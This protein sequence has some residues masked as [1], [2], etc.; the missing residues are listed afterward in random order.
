MWWAT[1]VAALLVA[2]PCAPHAQAVAYH[3]GTL[4][5]VL[6][7]PH[8]GSV[9]LG[10]PARTG[11]HDL[12]A[13]G[14]ESNMYALALKTSEALRQRCGAAPAVVA[15]RLHRSHVDVNRAAA[16]CCVV[17][18]GVSPDAKAAYDAYHGN[19]TVA[20]AQ[21]KGSGKA[22]IL[23]MHG[24]ASGRR[25]PPRIDVGTGATATELR[26]YPS[27]PASTSLDVFGAPADL[28]WGDHSLG[29]LLEAEFNG[30]SRACPSKGAPAPEAANGGT[31]YFSGG[32]ISREHSDATAVGGMQL[33][34]PYE[35]HSSSA[36]DYV[37]PPLANAIAA[38][39]THYGVAS[40]TAQPSGDIVSGA[41]LI[42]DGQSGRLPGGKT[43][44]R[45][46]PV[47]GC[48]GGCE[49]VKLRIQVDVVS[50]SVQVRGALLDAAGALVARTSEAPAPGDVT[51]S[52]Q[53]GIWV[54]LPFTPGTTISDGDYWH[55]VQASPEPKIRW[56]DSP[57][58]PSTC[59]TDAWADGLAAPASPDSYSKR[60]WSGA[61][62]GQRT[63]LHVAPP[64]ARPAPLP[65]LPPH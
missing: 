1:T 10:W 21:A 4:P 25:S 34:M 9:D 62:K 65:L 59:N 50:V 15:M 16:D 51:M 40:C 39:I 60:S 47:T 58:N 48:S 19:I 30:Q 38:F 63:V 33:E 22:L 54:D 3:P 57:P 44:Y 2:L 45:K 37:S 46:F 32:F 14:P 61:D 42:D 12:K 26:N 31:D 41:G 7:V 36:P 56:D 8:G 35:L 13:W 5:V 53:P 17:G 27:A 28:L 49:L 55:A 52:L 43:C 23:D 11:G 24:M 64:L 20:V 6:S 18:G 29:T